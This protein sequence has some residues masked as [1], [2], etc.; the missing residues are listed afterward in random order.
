MPVRIIMWFK[1]YVKPQNLEK[2]IKFS[3]LRIRI[4]DIT[5]HAIQQRQSLQKVCYVMY[6]Y[7]G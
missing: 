2:P 6:F 4:M 3:T 7:P 1:M 5:H